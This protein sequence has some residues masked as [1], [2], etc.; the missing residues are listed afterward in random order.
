[1]QPPGP[2]QEIDWLSARARDLEEELQAIKERL[3][4]LTKERG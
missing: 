4:E 2:E 1:M 3:D